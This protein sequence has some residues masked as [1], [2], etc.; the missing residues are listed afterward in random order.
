MVELKAFFLSEIKKKE[1]IYSFHA[2][3]AVPGKKEGTLS[4]Y[5]SDSMFD[6]FL[7]ALFF[8]YL[9]VICFLCCIHRTC[10]VTWR[11]IDIAI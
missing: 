10:S 4:V 1:D 9:R 11:C 7:C 8:L 3:Q 5:R 2:Y 6:I